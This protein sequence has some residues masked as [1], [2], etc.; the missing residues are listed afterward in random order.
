M[1]N[2]KH[3]RGQDSGGSGLVHRI[4][5][6]P[7]ATLKMPAIF[8]YLPELDLLPAAIGFIVGFF[9]GGKVSIAYSNGGTR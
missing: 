5:N 2:E 8:R 7:V 9:C 6:K 3:Q 1:M 4:T